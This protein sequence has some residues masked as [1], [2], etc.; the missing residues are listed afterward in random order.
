MCQIIWNLFLCQKLLKLLRFQ[1]HQKVR[2]NIWASLLNQLWKNK[3]KSK[4]EKRQEIKSLLSQKI[5][6]SNLQIKAHCK[7]KEISIHNKYQK[8]QKEVFYRLKTSNIK[9]WLKLWKIA[10]LTMIKLQNLSNM[11]DIVQIQDMKK[12]K[13]N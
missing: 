8:Y 11:F 5:W 9:C 2:G 4:P 12:L 13:D 10:K 7:T 3:L 1:K 6:I